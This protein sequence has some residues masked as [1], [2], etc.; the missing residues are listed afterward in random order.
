MRVRVRGSA[1][2]RTIGITT[3]QQYLMIGPMVMQH[4]VSQNT[5]MVSCVFMQSIKYSCAEHLSEHLQGRRF[6][7]RARLDPPPVWARIRP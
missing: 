4:I 5:K 3:G 6:C 2:M 7:A 1:H